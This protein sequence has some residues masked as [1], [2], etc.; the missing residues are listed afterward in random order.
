M[1]KTATHKGHLP[2]AE[3]IVQMNAAMTKNPMTESMVS[4]Y[5]I[6]SLWA[7]LSARGL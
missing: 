1:S 7:G 5:S 4:P 2:N 6:A 3:T